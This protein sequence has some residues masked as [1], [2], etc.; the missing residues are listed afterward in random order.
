MLIYVA[1]LRGYILK[2]CR[3]ENYVL[4]LS[5]ADFPRPVLRKH[6]AS[7]Q[8]LIESNGAKIRRY[9]QLWVWLK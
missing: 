7:Q 8:E 2:F 1:V 9:Q 4:V 3:T 5:F 6:R